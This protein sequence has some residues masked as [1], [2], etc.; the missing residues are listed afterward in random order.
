MKKDKPLKNIVMNAA[1]VVGLLGMAM[2]GDGNPVA[3]VMLFTGWSTILLI[4]HKERR[5]DE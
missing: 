4:S 5:E 3:I 1:F 2:Y